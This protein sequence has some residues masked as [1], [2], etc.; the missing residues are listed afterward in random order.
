MTS[1]NRDRQE[2]I[3]T[4]EKS[5]AAVKDHDREAWL[6]FFAKHNLVE[7]PV[8]S[9][10][11]HSGCFDAK[12]G[13]RHRGALERFYD[14]F[15]APNQITFHVNRDIICGYHAIRDLF[16]EITMSDKVT[17]EVPMHIIYELTEEEGEI[18]AYRLAAHWQLWPMIVQLAGKGLAS[19]GVLSS[20]GTRM[21]SIQ[22]LG[23]LIGFMQGFRGIGNQGKETV[24]AFTQALNNKSLATMMSLFS[25]ANQGIDF[26]Y[27]GEHFAPDTIIDHVDAKL[28][29]SKQLSAGY[30]STCSFALE[31]NGDTKNGVAFFEFNA[32]NK[33]IDAARFYWDEA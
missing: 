29:I 26:P 12:S 24:M 5:P 17:I 28:S 16:L 21:I 19:L 2:L 1:A 20:L 7:D 27:G 9:K 8:G 4:I 23:G 11:H 10:G 18:K 3:D 25:A 14:T 31:R 13:T 30:V 22:G 33:K 6:A 32:K 15:I